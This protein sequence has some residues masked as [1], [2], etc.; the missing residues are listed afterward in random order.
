MRSQNRLPLDLEAR[1]EY[2]RTAGHAACD[3]CGPQCETR[4]RAVAMLVRSRLELLFTSRGVS[5]ELA[6]SLLRAPR[7]AFDP[8]V[9]N[10]V[11]LCSGRSSSETPWTV[12]STL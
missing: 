4:F 6:A 1:G 10:F 7:K 9:E 11:A 12:P 8:S 2:A 5:F 3:L